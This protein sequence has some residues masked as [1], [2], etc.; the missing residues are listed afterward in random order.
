MKRPFVF[1][2]TAFYLLLFLFLLHHT[3]LAP[4]ILGRYKI[5]YV[6]LLLVYLL[7]LIP[8]IKMVHVLDA[9]HRRLKFRN[10][11]LTNLIHLTL[12]AASVFLALLPLEVYLRTHYN[13]LFAY[14]SIEAFHPFLQIQ[15]VKNDP[16]RLLN[17]YGFYGPEIQKKKPENTFRIFILGGSTA[18]GEHSRIL[19]R[20]LKERYP[21]QKIE[22]LNA[23]YQWYTSE[24]SIIDY[25]FRV[26]DFEPDLIICW[27]GIN[28]LHRS[29]FS[30][31]VSHGEFQ[32]DYSHYYGPM[33]RMVFDYFRPPPVLKISLLS[34]QLG[35]EQ[36]SYF[37]IQWKWNL[38]TPHFQGTDSYEFPSLISF[39]R[40]MDSLIQIL[41]TDGVKLVLGTQPFLYREGL[42]DRELKSL[43]GYR[44]LSE[45]SQVYPS[46]K[47]IAQAMNQFNEATKD[48]A[49]KYNIPFVD[50]DAQMP[51]TSEYL[52]DDVHYTTKGQTLVAELFF[53]ELAKEQLLK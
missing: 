35:V 38:Q 1:L 16:L 3:S 15:P 47:S 45:R 40:N 7:F 34:V 53:R 2:S 11:I 10:I 37:L 18:A 17:S 12:F 9:F 19:E 43:W 27:H 48:L 26:K 30:K 42:S 24:H 31:S 51:K 32:S 46:L 13:Q 36:L 49:K 6:I 52:S 44:L 41:Q 28:D 8:F 14:K 22:V 4:E 21:N 33:A 50:L 39:R 20:L 5:S 25:L 23:A 29:L